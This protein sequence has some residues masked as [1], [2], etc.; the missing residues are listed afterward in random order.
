[1]LHGLSENSAHNISLSYIH[2]I[3]IYMLTYSIVYIDYYFDNEDR[4]LDD[5]GRL[6]KNGLLSVRA[7]LSRFFTHW[8]K[9]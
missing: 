1:M 2:E 8:L 5:V 4:N 3:H 7:N 9:F 6:T